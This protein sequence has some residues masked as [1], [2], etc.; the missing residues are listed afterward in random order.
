MVPDKL[1]AMELL[2]DIGVNKILTRGTAWYKNE[3]AIVCIDRWCQII[4][5][6]KSQIDI[7]ICEGLN[8]RT[9]GRILRY[10]LMR[11]NKISVQ[12]YSGITEIGNTALN[13]VKSL[14]NAVKCI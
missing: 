2:I 7:D 1:E 8:I 5:K 14:V 13:Q 10:L 11:D 4:E 12:A 3:T 9:V 6:V